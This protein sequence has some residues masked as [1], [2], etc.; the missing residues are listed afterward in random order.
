MGLLEW[1]SQI[2][3][4]TR[5][6][7]LLFKK[8][9]QLISFLVKDNG[10]QSYVM[11]YIPVLSCLFVLK[12]VIS[13]IVWQYKNRLIVSNINF[14]SGYRKQVRKICA[15]I[16][17]VCLRYNANSIITVCNGPIGCAVTNFAVSESI[18]VLIHKGNTA[19]LFIGIS[20]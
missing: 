3:H 16:Q 17:T 20:K 2:L 15:S 14:V 1:L 8:V 10:Y 7:L 12:T 13:T 19:N 4:L 5:Q 18:F 9:I 11:Q 6:F